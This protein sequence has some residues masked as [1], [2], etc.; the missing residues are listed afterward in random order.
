MS[1]M[2][3]SIPTLSFLAFSF[4]ICLV[5]RMLLES[6]DAWRALSSLAGLLV[7]I[8]ILALSWFRLSGWWIIDGLW[9]WAW[10]GDE[11]EW[12]SGR[13]NSCMLLSTVTI[14]ETNDEI[15]SV[16]EWSIMQMMK[17]VV[18]VGIWFWPLSFPADWRAQRAW[19]LTSL[20]QCIYSTNAE[21][22]LSSEGRAA[23]LEDRKLRA[24][25]K[26]WVLL[27]S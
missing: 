19:V 8:F 2:I 6:T 25:S 20:A 9:M 12:S 13:A 4:C 11:L 14:V 16:L 21:S 18:R 7:W 27:M 24:G 1:F 26:M 15:Q 3:Y 22:A 10:P 17:S 23:S 5:S